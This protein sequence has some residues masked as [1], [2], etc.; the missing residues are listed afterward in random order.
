MIRTAVSKLGP[1]AKPLA[2]LLLFGLA[3]AAHAGGLDIG[4]DPGE[5]WQELVVA[6]GVVFAIPAPGYSRAK[7]PTG[8]ER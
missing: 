4:V 7:I 1:F 6:V 2:L 3:T 8:S 5:V